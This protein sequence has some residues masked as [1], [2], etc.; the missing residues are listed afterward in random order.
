MTTHK[1]IY[2]VL[3]ISGLLIGSLIGIVVFNI[4]PI[5]KAKNN[6]LVLSIKFADSTSALGVYGR[7]YYIFMQVDAISPNGKTMT[8]FH[9]K[10]N[11]TKL[12][13][14][15]GHNRNFKRIIDAWLIR[16]KDK[17]YKEMVETALFVSLWII[18]H[19]NVTY[20]VVPDKVISFNP[21]KVISEGIVKEINIISRELEK[22]EIIDRAPKEVRSGLNKI[23]IQQYPGFLIGYIWELE[24]YHSPG[25]CE[26]PVL[27]AYNMDETSAG[28]TGSI[29]IETTN[30]FGFYATIAYG[31]DIKA[32]AENGDYGSISLTLYKSDG[33]TYTNK[34]YF[35]REV[36]ISGEE[37]E[38]IYI[39]AKPVYALYKE[40]L[41]VYDP[42]TGIIVYKTPTGDEKIRTFVADVQVINENI[43]GNV[44]SG[45][46][47]NSNITDWFFEGVYLDH[48]YLPGEL[49]D[50]DLDPGE[51]VA[52]PQILSH[53]DIH[54]VGFSIGVPI[55]AVLAY[56]LSSVGLEAIA[57]VIAGFVVSLNYIQEDS[58]YVSGGLNN[59]GKEL[60]GGYDVSE[61]VYIAISNYVFSS[62]SGDYNVPAG[63]YVLFDTVGYS[64]SPGCPYLYVYTSEGFVNEGL[65]NIHSDSNIDVTHNHTIMNQPTVINGR[66][67]FKL[68]EHE[69]TISYIDC[70]KL[71]AILSNGSIIE[72]PLLKAVHKIYGNVLPWLLYDDDF[73]IA[74]VGA[75]HT[76]SGSHETVSYTHLTLP[77]T[78]RV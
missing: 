2:I 34:A 8:I 68:V 9:G 18:R 38:Y 11:G 21:I 5:V 67:I 1:K 22:V 76:P 37:K 74:S 40:Y 36:S 10:L 12:V 47:P 62:P 25:L 26:V 61:N 64:D 55:G 13:I 48:L 7:D 66:Y 56:A 72:F 42:N 54:Q 77:T 3:F 75:R 78:E 44:K 20:R 71:F 58:I 60:V 19:D 52:L 4:I 28:V 16:L 63:L 31:Y 59:L 53:Y 17:P 50:G 27:M 33:A 49:A 43:V 41:V 69:K 51:T 45:L 70:V 15:V 23:H 30:T 65:L 29:S 32:K 14:D 57:P 46:S 73:R 6:T 24:D 39:I 35:Y